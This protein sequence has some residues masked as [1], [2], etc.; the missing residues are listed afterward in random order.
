[1]RAAHMIGRAGEIG[2]RLVLVLG[3]LAYQAGP[4]EMAVD[5]AAKCGLVCVVHGCLPNYVINVLSKRAQEHARL[6]S[7]LACPG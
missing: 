2:L 3:R 1:M 5:A 7:L 4:R 6:C